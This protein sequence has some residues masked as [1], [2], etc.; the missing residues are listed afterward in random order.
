MD[1]KVRFA[2]LQGQKQL[3]NQEDQRQQQFILVSFAE[4]LFLLAAKHSILP[5]DLHGEY[6]LRLGRS[7]SNRF[8]SVT[9][10]NFS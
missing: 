4:L 2:V 6:C 5:S 9:L 8:V 1:L 3:Q 10:R 7:Y